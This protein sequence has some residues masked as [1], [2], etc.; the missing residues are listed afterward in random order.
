M[1]DSSQGRH[2]KSFE[3]DTHPAAWLL[4]FLSRGMEVEL[5]L[6][7]RTDIVEDMSVI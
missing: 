7:N 2:G 5:A 1:A 3:S 6:E 4:G